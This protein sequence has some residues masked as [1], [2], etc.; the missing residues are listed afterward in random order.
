L[1]VALT[2]RVLE[3]VVADVADRGCRLDSWLAGVQDTL[4]RSRIQKSIEDGLVT[5]DDRICRKSK[6]LVEVGN[7][8]SISIL[9]PRSLELVPEAIDLDILYEDEDV[10]VIN[11]PAGMVVHPSAGHDSKTLVHALL[12]YCPL[13]QIGDVFRPGIVHRL[14]RDTT[15]AIVVAKTDLAHRELQEQLRL[16]TAKREYIGVVYGAIKEYTGTIDFPVGRHPH[17][18]QKQA[19]V[20]LEKGGRTAVTHW[21]VRERYGN[22]TLLDFQLETGRTHQIRIHCAH[23]RHPIVGDPLYSKGKSIGVNLCGQAL[24]AYRLTFRHPR[25]DT[26]IVA[27]APIPAEFHKLVDYLAKLT[28]STIQSHLI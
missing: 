23:I 7:R 20:P 21:Q 25:T 27:E 16:K 8:I 3:F 2:E 18:R 14:D 10:I 22:Y 24:H 1:S 19:I 4:S 11:K 9:P 28:G 15:G 6:T 5:I 17:D 13:A 12:A 26:E